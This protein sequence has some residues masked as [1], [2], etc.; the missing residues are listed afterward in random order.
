[1][2]LVHCYKSLTGMKPSYCAKN[3]QWCGDLARPE[4]TEAPGKGV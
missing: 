4:T 3:A 1:M 2:S